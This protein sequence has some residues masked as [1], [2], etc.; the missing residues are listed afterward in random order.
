V[1]TRWVQRCGVTCAMAAWVA[2]CACLLCLRHGRQRP[3][4]H[5]A[6]G[7]QQ[8]IAAGSMQRGESLQMNQSACCLSVLLLQLCGPLLQGC[9]GC[10]CCAVQAAGYSREYTHTAATL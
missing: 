7:G 5:E 2:M 9:V 4:A 10:W 1:C 3:Q 8:C 6:A